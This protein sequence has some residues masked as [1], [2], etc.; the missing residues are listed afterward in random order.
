MTFADLKTEILTRAKSLE[1][2]PAYHAA[3]IATDRNGLL[4]AAQDL[5]IWSYQAGV[6]D[7]TLLDEFTDGELNPYGIYKG[8]EDLTN[9]SID[10][11]Y[12]KSGGPN[13]TIDGNNKCKISVM[14]EVQ[15]QLTLSD[16]AYANV[17]CYDESL[18]NIELDTKA[19]CN[20]ELVQHGYSAIIASDDSFVQ[21]IASDNT[22]ASYTGNNNSRAI[23]KG[24]NHTL[25]NYITNDSA[26]VT[27]NAYG[28][29]IITN[30]PV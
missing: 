14:G 17:K 26:S 27:A 28:Q 18:A 25:I 12:F 3:L 9:P 10:I 19:S 6:V 20:L 11:Y 2:C 16:N 15:L 4:A 23:I 13:V 29:S 5:F 24:F 22:A 21:L 30:N 7:D 1:L 8:G